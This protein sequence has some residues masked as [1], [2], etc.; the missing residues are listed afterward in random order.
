[1]FGLR[2]GARPGNASTT[3]RRAI[4]QMLVVAVLY[5]AAARFSL[6]FAL[7]GRNITP[8]WPPTGIALVA[9]LRYG[10]RLWPGVMLGALLVNLPITNA[11]AAFATSVGNTIAPLLAARLLE[12]TGFRHTIDRVRD[13]TA[14]VLLAALLSMTVSAAVGTTSLVLSS[15]LPMS[16]FW[17][18]WSVW[19]A[20]DAMGVLVIAPFL[21]CLLTWRELRP[22]VGWQQVPEAALLFGVLLAASVFAVSGRSQLLF[23]DPS[24]GRMDRVA[25]PAPRRRSRGAPRVDRGRLGRGPDARLVRRS[26]AQVRHAHAP[27]LQRHGR[28]HGVLRGSAR[29]RTD[30]RERTPRVCRGRA[31]CARPTTNQPTERGGGAP[32]APDRG[33]TGGGTR[34]SSERTRAGQDPGA[35]APGQVGVGPRDGDGELV[36]RHVPHPRVR[37][38]SVRGVLRQDGRA[39]SRGGPTQGRTQPRGRPGRPAAGGARHRVPHRPCGRRAPGAA[40]PRT[41]VRWPSRRADEGDGHRDGHHRAP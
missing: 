4:F 24:D 38:R 6:R 11:L 26:L 37:A 27:A 41:P 30:P 2:P 25:V 22:E 21:L 29:V 19:W 9:F 28:V 13:V 17:E 7:I 34:A 15:D 16:R 3:T 1:M 18:A 33:T 12:R 20:G 5:Y 40:Q 8:L 10:K 23:L 39:R 36:R 35:R 31:R 14:L 32:R